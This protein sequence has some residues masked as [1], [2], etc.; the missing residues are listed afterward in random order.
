MKSIP[1]LCMN[2]AMT[3]CLLS[4]GVLDLRI[5]APCLNFSLNLMFFTVKCT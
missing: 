1:F 4:V 5:V 2:D 3:C